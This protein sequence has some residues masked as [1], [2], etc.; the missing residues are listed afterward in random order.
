[1]GDWKPLKTLRVRIPHEY[2]IS[3]TLNMRVPHQHKIY[4]WIVPPRTAP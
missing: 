1:M 3:K 2:V 4:Y